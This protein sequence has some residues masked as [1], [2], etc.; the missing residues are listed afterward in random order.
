MKKLFLSFALLFLNAP[1]AN[2][3]NLEEALVD[4]YYNNPSLKSEIERQKA[5]DENLPQ[6]Y[7]GWLPNLSVN[8]RAGKEKEKFGLGAKEETITPN[9]TTLTLKQSLFS[10]G[11]TYA[12]INQAYNNILSGQNRLREIEQRVLLEAIKAYVDLVTTREILALSKK[13]ESALEEQLKSTRE[14][15]QLGETTKTD[16]SQ[17]ESRLARGQSDR[18]NADGNYISARSQY[19]KIFLTE[20]PNDAS[21][22]DSLPSIKYSFGEAKKIALVNNPV[23]KTSEYNAAAADD[24][25]MI[26]ASSL[27]P[28]VDLTAQAQRQDNVSTRL[29]ERIEDKS[30]FFNVSI[31]LYQSGYQYSRLRQAKDNAQSAKFQLEDAVNATIDAL[32]KAWRDIQTSRA[33][34]KATSASVASA[35]FALEGVR[36]EQEI[37]SRTTLDILDAEQELFVAQVGLARAKQD[38]V[39]AVYTLKSVLGELTA[40][41]LALN[42]DIYKAEKHFKNTKYKMIGF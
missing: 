1:L 15:F 33:N 20:P 14:R 23:L 36:Q 31:P 24:S 11:R 32:T 29:G 6:A 13:N 40:K 16:V 21:I 3:L 5:V 10:G 18:I 12:G 30:V 39:V 8:Y 27:L 28:Q 38:E 17:A 22:P 2:A 26:S 42:V 19:R 25:V 35:R 4:A 34:I 9:T 41:D 7:S 37:G